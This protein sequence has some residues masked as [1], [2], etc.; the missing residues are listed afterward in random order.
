MACRQSVDPSAWRSTR[1]EE[2]VVRFI[3]MHDA[4]AIARAL[5]ET[6]ADLGDWLCQLMGICG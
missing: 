1:A 4:T 2:P 6:T 5:T 3:E